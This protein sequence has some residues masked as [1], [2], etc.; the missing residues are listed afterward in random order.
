MYLQQKSRALQFGRRLAENSRICPITS[1]LWM[2]VYLWLNQKLRIG[3]V[4]RLLSCGANLW[5]SS[6]NIRPKKVQPLGFYFW[7]LRLDLFESLQVTFF[8]GETEHMCLYTF[9]GTSVSSARKH[10]FCNLGARWYNIFNFVL[11]YLIYGWRPTLW[12]NQSLESAWWGDIFLV[13][14]TFKNHPQVFGK[15]KQKTAPWILFLTPAPRPPQVVFFCWWNWTYVFVSFCGGECVVSFTSIPWLHFLLVA[16]F[17]ISE[18]ERQKIN[19]HCGQW[20]C[21]PN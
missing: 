3:L 5:R 12:P 1:Y 6:A 10:L 7:H 17:V 18:L 16:T 11:S 14:P 20:Y 2:K 15:K 13:G 9:A 19:D 4:M 8:V 21:C